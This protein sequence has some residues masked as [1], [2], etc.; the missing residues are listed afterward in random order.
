MGIENVTIVPV[1]D[2]NRYGLYA[3]YIRSLLPPFDAVVTHSSLTRQLFSEKGYGI[4]SPGLMERD[5]LSG[6]EIRR[7]ITANESW[8]D[9]VP[10]AVVRV[11]E[12]IDGA[13]RLRALA[14]KD[15]PLENGQ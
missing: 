9:L 8:Q 12:R 6:T 11:L 13:S 1:V 7:R 14:V 10:E 2:L 4:I 5:V 15:I 3:E